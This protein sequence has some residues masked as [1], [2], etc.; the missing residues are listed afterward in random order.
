M[1]IIVKNHK[2]QKNSRHE[3]TIE[4]PAKR[5]KKYFDLAYQRL[6]PQVEISGFRPGKAPRIMTLQRI[7]Y[8]RY[9]QTTFDFALPEIYTES[10][11]ELKIKPVSPPQITPKSYGEDM[12]LILDVAVDVLPEVELND[13]LKIKVKA[14]KKDTEVSAKEIDKVIE[15]LRHQQAQVNPVNRAAKTGDHVE[16]DFI[17]TV[18]NVV[19]DEYSSKHFPLILGKGAIDQKIEKSLLGKKRGDIYELD[20]TIKKDK[21]HF[22]ITVH[23][24]GEI[25][26]P[27][28]DKKFAEQFGKKSPQE[29]KAAI[30]KQLETEREQKHLRDSEQKVINALLKKIKIDAPKS[31]V[32][33]EIQRRV[34]D[35]KQQFG[36]MYNEFLK[37][38]KWQEKDLRKE[39]TKPAEDAVKAGILLGAIAQKESLGKNRPKDMDDHA[40]QAYVA[41][42]TLDWLVKK[43]VK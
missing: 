10:I 24:V 41:R 42:L 34:A 36:A 29:L 38:R 32:N 21:V 37:S 43:L 9:F 5:M 1:N 30:K 27:D 28:I 7:G 14:P 4:V 40:Y 19:R 18:D 39:L 22:K 17:G 31:L 23:E 20:T 16:I 8:D 26:L 33:E 12:P 3:F 2:K 25:K 15:R 11:Q 13:Y 35:I 6:A